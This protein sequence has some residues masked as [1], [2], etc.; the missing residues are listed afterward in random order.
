MRQRAVREWWHLYRCSQWLHLRLYQWLHRTSV[1]DQHQRT[2]PLV[3][4]PFIRRLTL[5]ARGV[6]NVCRNV[7]LRRAR[8][9]R[10]VW[11]VLTRSHA[12][13]ARTSLAL[14]ASTTVVRPLRPPAQSLLRMC[15]VLLRF[16]SLSLL[17]SGFF[18]AGSVVP[19]SGRFS[20]K[21]VGDSSTLDLS[22]FNRQ[23]LAYLSTTYNV[24]SSRFRLVS[25]LPIQVTTGG[26]V[27]RTMTVATGFE[28]TVDVVP[29]ATGPSVDDL[30]AQIASNPPV[31][32]YAGAAPVT[33]ES[34]R[35]TCTDGIARAS[36][37]PSPSGLS[38]AAIG[39]II[40]AGIFFLALL[41]VIYI[42]FVRKQP[43]KAAASAPAA[44]AAAPAAAS[45]PA[46]APAQ[47][48]PQPQPQVAVEMTSL[49]HASDFDLDITNATPAVLKVVCLLVCL[50][51]RCVSH[52]YFLLF[53]TA[54]RLYSAPV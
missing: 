18:S 9:V 40:G 42:L 52:S 54:V 28:A 26:S 35:A 47:P 39:A 4:T 34:I 37:G 23:L 16:V 11:T 49:G 13:V 32:A 41:I 14:C 50:A 20:L 53:V 33:N 17:T 27:W 1:S 2:L 21:W 25:I 15:A 36:C 46:P 19:G 22:D 24:P 30:L 3:F 29:A 45:A 44:R 48:Q 7:R 43:A 12:R 5:N 8:T 31:F 6:V 51:M 10:P 38:A